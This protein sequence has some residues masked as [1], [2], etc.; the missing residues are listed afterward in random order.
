MNSSIR[1]A[2]RSS[3][4]S[5]STTSLQQTATIMSISRLFFIGL[6]LIVAACGTPAEGASPN[7]E[8][9]T[10]VRL[11]EVVAAG[12]AAAVT[13]T[14]TLGAKDEVA[15]SFK[16]GGIIARVLVDEGA[17]VRRGQ[18]LAVLDQR[19]IDAMVAKATAGA[20]KAERDAAR[21]E[22]LFQDSVVTLVQLQD[23]QTGRAAA[24]ADLRATRVNHEFSTIVAPNDGVIL[25]RTGNPGQLVGPGTAVIQFASKGRGSVLR[26]GLPDRDAVTVRRGTPAQVEI[27]SPLDPASRQ[28]GSRCSSKCL[29][30]R[31]LCCCSLCSP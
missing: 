10:P 4:P 23:A 16:I 29:G 14:G 17:R 31:R 18:V 27:A 3:R 21:A 7:A 1:L 13:A 11:A 30:S 20:E 22:R 8:S 6:P 12:S 26:A 19:E 28:C 24:Q 2:S 5:T 9:V 25:S 15:L